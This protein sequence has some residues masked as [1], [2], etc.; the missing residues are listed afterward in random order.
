M[1]RVQLSQL[2][3][4]GKLPFRVIDWL[5]KLAPIAVHDELGTLYKGCILV[6]DDFGLYTAVVGTT[7]QLLK[8][9]SGEAGEI[10]TYKILKVSNTICNVHLLREDLQ[11]A[12]DCNIIQ[13]GESA[14][15]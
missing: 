12:V 11:A 8:T 14:V 2:R 3:K 15:T 13:R 7:D 1:D 6:K 4:T 5:E 9:S 10:P